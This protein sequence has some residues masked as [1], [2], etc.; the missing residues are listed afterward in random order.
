MSTILLVVIDVAS[1]PGAFLIK[2]P[3]KEGKIG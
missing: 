2:A 1:G 3:P